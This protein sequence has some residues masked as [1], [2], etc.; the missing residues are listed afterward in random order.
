MVVL[1]WK[2]SLCPWIGRSTPVM[3]TR[4]RSGYLENMTGWSWRVAK[5]GGIDIRIH[6]TFLLLLAWIAWSRYSAAGTV[7][8][9]L[10]GV[11]FTS[12][13]FGIVVLHELGHALT[14]RHYG[15]RTRDITLWPIGGVAALE[16]MPDTPR[17]ELAVAVAGPAVNAAL[18]A[19]LA[20]ILWLEGSSVFVADVVSPHEALLAQLLWVNVMLAGFNLLPAFPMDGGRALRALLAMRLD[21]VRATEVAATI[22]QALAIV[23]GFIGLFFNPVLL[24]IALF[25]WLGA[26]GEARVAR[27]KYAFSGVPVR[28]AMLTEVRVLSPQRSVADAVQL[29]LSCQ[30]GDFPVLEGGTL[31][32]LLS[33][34]AIL[35]ALSNRGPEVPVAEV[36][37]TDVPVTHPNAMLD[38]AFELLQGA[39]LRSLPVVW[40]DGKLAGLVTT[41]TIGELML[42]HS[43]LRERGRKD[44]N[45]STLHEAWDRHRRS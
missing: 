34:Q 30:Q 15:V 22:G 42:V 10:D 16:R 36:M 18:A 43:T 29:A 25:V 21:D 20:V 39:D 9:A 12:I 33:R 41:E 3:E 23:F 35:D 7:S 32:G 19:I 1:L 44:R 40:P 11:L 8:A 31:V 4:P 14:A 13:V 45:G 27:M 5:L 26:A 28:Y 6:A 38:E 2:V 37:R 17:A 24:F